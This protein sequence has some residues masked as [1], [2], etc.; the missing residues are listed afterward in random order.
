MIGVKF[1]YE[2]WSYLN[3][4]SIGIARFENYQPSIFADRR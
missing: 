2:K 3:G 4:L 1:F